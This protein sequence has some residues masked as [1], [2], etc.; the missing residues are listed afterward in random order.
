MYN[1]SRS[2]SSSDGRYSSYA[3]A[4][5]EVP[6]DGAGSTY[7]VPS[8]YSYNPA[9]Q[10]SGSQSPPSLAITKRRTCHPAWSPHNNNNNNN[11][12]AIP[13]ECETHHTRRRVTLRG[14]LRSRRLLP[15]TAKLHPHTPGS[16]SLSRQ[17]Y[18]PRGHPPSSSSHPRSPTDGRAR[19]GSGQY[20]H[21]A[22]NPTAAVASPPERFACHICKKSFSR[23]HDRKRHHVGQHLD[24]HARPVCPNCHKDFS[25]P[26][27]LKRHRDNGCDESAT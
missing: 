21:L 18:Y 14:G 17:A 3:S 12:N 4:G 11:N 2:H 16:P 23:S 27:S 9:Q 5:H 13:P 6:V 15:V 19:S 7:P 8:T 25:R 24:S 20:R 26:D 1:S 22:A 10:Y